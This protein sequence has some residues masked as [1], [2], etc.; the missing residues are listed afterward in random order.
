M[1]RIVWPDEND[2][3]ES[4]QYVR[5][6]VAATRG[7]NIDVIFE[8]M[9][10]TRTVVLPEQK[11]IAID[12]LYDLGLAMT[13]KE[14]WNYIREL[15]RNY[16]EIAQSKEMFARGKRWN[17]TYMLKKTERPPIICEPPSVIR[18]DELKCTNETCRKL[19]LH[20]RSHLTNY[21]LFADDCVFYPYYAILFQYP[22]DDEF[23]W[24][25]EF[26]KGFSDGKTSRNLYAGPPIKEQKDLKKI[27]VSNVME[28]IQNKK[29]ELLNNPDYQTTEELLHDIMPTKFMFSFFSWIG[30]IAA[31]M[32]GMTELLMNMMTKPDMVHRL[33]GIIQENE[34][35]I[36]DTL[37]QNGI[38]SEESNCR[39]TASALN[40]FA[41]SLKTTPSAVPVK[42]GDLWGR[43]ESQE[44]QLVSPQMTNEFLFEY[45]KPIM[46]RFRYIGFGCCENLTKKLDYLIQIPN[47][48]VVVNSPW[49]DLKTTVEKC[50]DNY[51]I[52]WRQPF[53]EIM[54]AKSDDDIRKDLERGLQITRGCY[55]AILCQE[56]NWSLVQNPVR[57]AKKWIEEARRSA[58]KYAD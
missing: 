32:M 17:D 30:G 43:F 57:R 20:F 42:L 53:S 18:E 47:L 12:I 49:T 38:F 4:L 46:S 23:D 45:Q 34:L 48:R 36:L 8:R 55:R 40:P 22:L 41:E 33:L 28:G 25:V 44:F 2:M 13:R 10:K 6:Y 7:T 52:L 21:E 14:E 24:G 5:E 3:E 26:I 1:E 9:G 27:R 15:A 58:E 56:V 51:T 54:F 35:H 31:K 19:E 16:M 29:R 39:L 37:E 50:R 11:W